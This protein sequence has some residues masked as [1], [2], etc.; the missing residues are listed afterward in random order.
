MIDPKKINELVGDIM[1][2]LPQGLK[3]MPQELQSHLKGSMQRAFDKM[4]LVTREEFDVQAAV[5][6][7]TREK[8]DA[9]EKKCDELLKSQD[10][11]QD[12]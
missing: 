8:L 7:R 4:D 10:T 2:S 1:D 6:K 5:L 11:S 3:N 12:S 9:L